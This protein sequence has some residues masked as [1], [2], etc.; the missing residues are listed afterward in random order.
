MRER[1]HQ[2]LELLHLDERSAYYPHNNGTGIILAYFVKHE[3]TK[4]GFTDTRSASNSPSLLGTHNFIPKLIV[5]RFG[6]IDAVH[7]LWCP[8]SRFLVEV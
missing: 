7:K 4:K 2:P 3:K 5:K 1:G 6:Y 8:S